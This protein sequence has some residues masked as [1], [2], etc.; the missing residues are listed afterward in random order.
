VCRRVAGP[1]TE[2]KRMAASSGATPEPIEEPLAADPKDRG[3]FTESSLFPYL[4]YAVVFVGV[5]IVVG[6]ASVDNPGVRQEESGVLLDS[7]GA[8]VG[9]LAVVLAAVALLLAFLTGPYK[10]IIEA[11]GV[12]KFFWPFVPVAVLSAVAA[13]MGMAGAL[14]SDSGPE[15]ARATLDGIALGFFAAAVTGVVYLVWV[16]LFHAGVRQAAEKARAQ[17][18]KSRQPGGTNTNDTNPGPQATSK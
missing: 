16:F 12:R 11:V 2:E 18:S 4:L 10:Q 17:I 1:E 8:A 5:G 6:F 7:G 15:D 13:I 3:R 14:D 9:L